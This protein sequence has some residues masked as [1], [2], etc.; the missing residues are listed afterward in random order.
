M[1]RINRF[2]LLIAALVMSKTYN[3]AAI[4]CDLTSDVQSCA[5]TL[6]DGRLYYQSLYSSVMCNSGWFPQDADGN[7][8]PGKSY[9]EQGDFD[10]DEAV[11]VDCCR[12]DDSCLRWYQGYEQCED[13]GGGS[14]G[15]IDIPTC[16]NG[17]YLDE[18][19]ISCVKCPNYSYYAG[20]FTG[21]L[22]GGNNYPDI[23]S[24]SN[25]SKCY[26]PVGKAFADNTGKYEFAFNCYYGS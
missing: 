7:P 21:T 24:D 26:V 2:Y 6:A 19:T 12:S 8:I 17:Y 1:A 23:G 11:Y 22:G 5:D 3:A 15:E 14:G 16:G 10:L 9:C 25:I 18:S 13:E 20:T 4:H